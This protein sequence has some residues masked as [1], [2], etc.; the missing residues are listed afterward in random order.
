MAQLCIDGGTSGVGC[1]CC[2]GY[3][4]GHILNMGRRS[5][6]RCLWC[7]FLNREGVR[8]SHV[9]HVRQQFNSM[10]ANSAHVRQS[11]NEVLMVAPTAFG[12]NDQVD[13]R[14]CYLSPCCMF[15]SRLSGTAHKMVCT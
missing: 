10:R 8:V 12:F 3:Q 11:T 9:P 4:T 7:R 14:S 2:L 1:S 15:H 6:Q 5:E 13:W